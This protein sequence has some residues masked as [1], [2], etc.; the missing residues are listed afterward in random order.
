M[1]HNNRTY[2]ELKG[3]SRQLGCV[4]MDV[5]EIKG[6]MNILKPKFT[7]VLHE[8]YNVRISLRSFNREAVKNIVTEM[9]KQCP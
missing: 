2:E 5:R 1:M 4:K 9:M 3:I 7:E 6:K 8:L